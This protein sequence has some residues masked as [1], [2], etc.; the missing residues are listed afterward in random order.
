MC[1]IIASPE[2]KVPTRGV[3]EQG[4]KD[5]SDGWGL[6]HSNG[7]EIVINKGLN[8]DHLKPLLDNLNGSPYVL[9]YRWA[10]HGNKNIDNCHP[11]QVTKQLYMAHNGV[12]SI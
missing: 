3:I 8:F 1:L 10:T 6:M 4:W 2:G 7:S 11:F 9:H 12:I 5:N